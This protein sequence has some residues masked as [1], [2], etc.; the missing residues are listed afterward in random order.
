MIYEISGGTKAQ[1][2]IVDLAMTAVVPMLNLKDN[3]N[4]E[5][6]LGKFD[7]SGVMDCEQDEDG[8][9]LF[10]MEINTATSL[11]ELAVTVFH[12]MKHVEQTVTGKLG[13]LTWKG[14]CHKDTP[15]MERPWEIEAYAFEQ[16]AYTCG[17]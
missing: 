13:Q 12:E 3:I 5:I 17:L 16:H 1:R 6:T 4:I 7:C 8:I 15:Y 10:D 9:H 14:K 2:K 11:Q